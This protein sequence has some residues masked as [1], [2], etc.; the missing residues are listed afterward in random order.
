MFGARL[1]DVRSLEQQATLAAVGGRLGRVPP[2]I[3]I[4]EQELAA[5]TYES[6]SDLQDI[7]DP[8]TVLWRYVDLCKWSTCSRRQSFT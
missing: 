3:N 2:R 6:H 8:D 1:P 4:N 7:E 5:M